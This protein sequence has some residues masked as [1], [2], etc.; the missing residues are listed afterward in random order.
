MR[1][2]LTLTYLALLA[3][4]LAG[5]G[6]YQYISLR[7]SL[8]A[9]RVAS[10]QSD[11]NTAR[12]LVARS[13][14]PAVRGARVL[15]L[16][17]AGIDLVG[18]AVATSV[19]T[20]SGHTVAVIVYDHNLQVAAQA[21]AGNDLPRLDPAG[22]QRAQ[23]GTRSNPEV[24][25]G[26]GGQDQLVVGFPVRS[27]VSAGKVCGV[28]QLSTS[29][30]PLQSVL[31]DD[32]TL[33]AAGSAIALLVALLAGL[34]LTGRAL[35]PLHQLT[36]TSR[37]LA[38][39][40]LRAR[41]GVEGR[42]DEIGELARSFD[43]MAARIEQSFAAQQESEGRTRRFIADASHELRTPLTALKGYID[44]IRRGATPDPAALD[45]AL[46]AMGRE[47]ERM[48]V[49]VLDLLTLA[50]LDAQR[51]A[52]PET[53]DLSELV[54]DVLDE[55]VPGMPAHITRELGAG[56]LAN[57]DRNAAA[58]IARNLL[59][60]ACK[61]APGAAQTW[62]TW[63]ADGHAYLAVHDDGPGIPA[64]DLP[65][66]FERFYRGEKTRAREEGG[67]GLGLSIVQG[68]ARTH[69]GDVSIDSIEGQ[70]ATVTVWFPVASPP[71][72][73]PAPTG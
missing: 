29:M 10:L 34:L 1:W 39:G 16:T 11:I 60:N 57:T 17:D 52:Q 32:L 68:L 50:R 49:L 63:T 23:A 27:G 2:R 4:L 61:Y 19:A 14:A 67:S 31:N 20:V 71:P 56:V 73:P 70:G 28:A 58:T 35:R 48:R 12:A 44:V 59:G 45:A 37:R 64:I 3:V 62:R 26:A 22:L 33:L 15:C 54:A 47:A 55:A 7:Q 5:F 38:G 6:L 21:P 13:T 41:S 46:E 18:R 40:D 30:A 42:H 53:L 43:D 72:P 25:A 24:V 8:I 69:G 66:I 51:Q 65:H 9:A 36:A